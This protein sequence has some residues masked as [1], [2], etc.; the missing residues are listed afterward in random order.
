[1]KTISKI[2]ISALI[3]SFVLPIFAGCASDDT[4]ASDTTASV[5]TASETSAEEIKTG[6]DLVEKKDYDGY[7]FTIAAIDPKAGSVLNTYSEVDGFGELTG[8]VIGDALYTRTSLTEEFFNIK[9]ERLGGTSHGTIG[10][11]LLKNIMAGDAF[12]DISLMNAYGL[13]KLLTQ[14]NAL[15]NLASVDTINLENDWWDQN[16]VESINV[17]GNTLAAVSDIN[18]RMLLGSV[19]TFANKRIAEEFNLGSNGDGNMYNDVRAGEWTF[20]RLYKYVTA[21]RHDT[22]GDGTINYSKDMIPYIYESLTITNYAQS[23]DNDLV[24]IDADGMPVFN[25]SVDKMQS[26]LE[27]TVDLMNLGLD[28]DTTDAAL[29]TSRFASGEVLFWSNQLYLTFDFRSMEDDYAVLP[30]PK[31]SEE[32]ESYR[33]STDRWHN[34]LTVMPI[35]VSDAERAGHITEGM[36]AISMELVTPVIYDITLTDKLIRDEDSVEMLEI[37]ANSRVYDIGYYFDWGDLDDTLRNL[38]RAKSKD[39]TSKYAAIEERF[40]TEM[41]KTILE[42]S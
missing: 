37:I 25:F 39:F 22:D 10:D 3:C 11:T 8:D 31:L 17:A 9:I 24:K 19:M 27:K 42:L 14:K 32:Q 6:I 5:T 16:S 33:T 18:L 30:L 21:A 15:I 2:I 26:T 41:D 35:T 36:S 13:P 1:M 29:C 23:A 4:S 12:C 20:D 34:T 7:T 28:L 40:M 38:V